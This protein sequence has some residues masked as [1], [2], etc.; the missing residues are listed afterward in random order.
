MEYFKQLKSAVDF[1]PKIYSVMAQEAHD[2][3]DLQTAILSLD[4]LIELD[5]SMETKSMAS[6]LRSMIQMDYQTVMDSQGS[7]QWDITI[8]HLRQLV[9]LIKSKGYY[10]VY[11]EPEQKEFEY[12]TSVAWNLAYVFSTSYVFSDWNREKSKNCSTCMNFSKLPLKY[13]L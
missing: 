9:H 7:A 10:D 6:V 3:G 12:V 8:R 5:T 1:D 2:S 4:Y 11:A 13:V